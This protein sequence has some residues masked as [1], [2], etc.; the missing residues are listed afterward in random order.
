MKIRHSP[1]LCRIRI[2][3]PVPKT[4]FCCR[5]EFEM[6]QDGLENKREQ[7]ELQWNEKEAWRFGEALTTISHQSARL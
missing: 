2:E 3:E 1:L 5:H 4:E 7:L 6:T